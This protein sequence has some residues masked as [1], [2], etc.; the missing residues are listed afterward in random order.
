[1]TDHIPES[2]HITYHILPLANEIVI[3]ASAYLDTDDDM[4]LHVDYL[5]Q[6]GAGEHLHVK[7]THKMPSGQLQYI[8]NLIPNSLQ[9]FL[10]GS[11]SFMFILL[12]FASC[13]TFLISVT[14]G[15]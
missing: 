7:T 8:T 11:C 6:V 15:N 13:Y 14:F 4:S 3:P 9:F 10:S 5:V 1:M 12:P 2:N